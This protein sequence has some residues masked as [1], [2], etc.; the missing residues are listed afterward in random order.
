MFSYDVP[1]VEITW[2]EMIDDD[3]DEVGKA[4]W[5]QI[6]SGRSWGVMCRDDQLVV[7][8]PRRIMELI[9]FSPPFCS[10]IRCEPAG[11]VSITS[12]HILYPP[13]SWVGYGT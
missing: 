7:G 12:S 6:S 10:Y 1:S 4:R 2:I 3:N 8:A 11:I 9:I 5:N 13:D